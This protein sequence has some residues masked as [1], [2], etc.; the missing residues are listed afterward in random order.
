MQFRLSIFQL[1]GRIIDILLYALYLCLSYCQPFMDSLV[2]G[3]D[4]LM[5]LTKFLKEFSSI[6]FV[7]YKIGSRKPIF[8]FPIC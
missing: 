1:Q 4:F 8:S 2:I 6:K 3:V 5:N 7:N